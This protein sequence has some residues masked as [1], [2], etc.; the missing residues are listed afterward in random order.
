MWDFSVLDVGKYAHK[1]IEKYYRHHYDP[2]AIESY[3][4]ILAYSYDELRNIWD[5]TLKPEQLKKSY[6]CLE[7][8]AKWEYE[9]IKHDICTLPDTE[10]EVLADGF[11]GFIDYVYLPKKLVID[12]KTNT[13]AYVSYDYRIQAAVYQILF[14][15]HYKMDLSHLK[16]FFL[17]PNEWRTIR[18]DMDKQMKA[19]EEAIRVKDEILS[20]RE[21]MNFP[22]RPRTPKKCNNCE[23]RNYCGGV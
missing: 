23:F 18:F 12:W 8:H 6:V 10:V 7:N 15:K 3:E 2:S 16:F 14:E 13:R 9:N 21:D 4:D 20:A 5:I 22:K 19:H 11:Y 17:Y 1:A